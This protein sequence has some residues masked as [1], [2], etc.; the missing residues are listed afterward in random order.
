MERDSEGNERYVKTEEDD[1]M[2]KA[3]MQQ[4]GADAAAECKGFT[5]D[6]R[7]DWVLKQKAIGNDHFKANDY[8]KAIDAYLKAL[9]G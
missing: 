6:E 3:K 2:L 8:A 5:F 1:V 4:L 7:F 9:C